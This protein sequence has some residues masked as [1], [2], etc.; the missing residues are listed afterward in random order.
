MGERLGEGALEG[1]AFVFGRK[2]GDWEDEGLGV[3]VRG[4]RGERRG[5]ERVNLM[6]RG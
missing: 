2:W 5:V 6:E 4:G 3:N 1:G